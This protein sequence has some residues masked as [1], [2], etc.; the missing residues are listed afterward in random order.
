MNRKNPDS[1]L[2]RP[3]AGLDLQTGVRPC[4]GDKA[5]PPLVTR[6]EALGT[7][8]RNTLGKACIRSIPWRV[9]SCW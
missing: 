7:L 6:Y 1:I 2:S 8:P 9:T 5:D 3:S 4:V